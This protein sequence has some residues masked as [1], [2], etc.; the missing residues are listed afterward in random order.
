MN[1]TI[2]TIWPAEQ[3]SILY[4]CGYERGRAF[5]ECGGDLRG[6]KQ[7]VENESRKQPYGFSSLDFEYGF[8]DGYENWE[9]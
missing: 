2:S 9:A 6:I 8:Y 5:A 4:N 7:E 3:D 1:I